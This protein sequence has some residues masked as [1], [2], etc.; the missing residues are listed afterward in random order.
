MEFL[1]QHTSRPVREESWAA[2]ASPARVQLGPQDQV[3]PLFGR[4]QARDVEVLQL[5]HDAQRLPGLLHPRCY[6]IQRARAAE[7]PHEQENQRLRGEVDRQAAE[8]ERR[9][10]SISATA[11]LLELRQRV[12]ALEQIVA[13]LCRVR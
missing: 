5:E 4:H 6:A 12:A 13:E 11:E 7:S 1:G 8:H 10:R 9:T 3:C 2:G